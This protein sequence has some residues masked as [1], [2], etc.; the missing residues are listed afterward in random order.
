MS[1]KKPEL[2]ATVVSSLLALILAS[3]MSSLAQVPGGKAF[4]VRSWTTANG[5]PQNSI[6]AIVQTRD[7]YL[8]MGTASGLVRF[9]G[10]KFKVFD[11]SDTPELKSDRILSL[12]EDREGALW[13]GTELGGLVRYADG[14]FTGF[15]TKDG[16]PS[17]Q[18]SEILEDAEGYTVVRTFGGTVRIK[19]GKV[20]SDP[21]YERFHDQFP[22]AYAR[23][24]SV[25][26]N[27]N[28]VLGHY[29]NGDVTDYDSVKLTDNSTYRGLYAFP[30][31][32]MIYGF[33]RILVAGENTWVATREALYRISQ[34]NPQRIDKV[35]AAM[36][37]NR[38]GQP[39]F[40]TAEGLCRFE[41]N[42]L[43]CDGPPAGGKGFDGLKSLLAEND[44]S[45]ALEDREGNVWIGTSNGLF[46]FR[47][48]VITAYGAEEGLSNSNFATITQDKSGVLWMG[49]VS[50]DRSGNIPGIFRF[51]QGRFQP[52]T[53]RP[54]AAA[55]FSDAGGTWIGDG[56]LAEF[57]DE[58]AIRNYPDMK[59]VRAILRDN[60][61]TV[62]IGTSD[63]NQGL[64]KLQDGNFTHYGSADGLASNNVH[65][66]MQDRQGALW[67]G[68]EGGVSRFKDGAFTTYNTDSGLSNNFVRDIYED[69][70]GAMWIA[71]YGGGLNRLKNGRIRQITTRDGLIENT[72]SRIL[73]DGLGNFWISGNRGI[74]KISLAQLN[75][76]C[77]GRADF[78]IPVAYGVSDGMKTAECNGGGQPA[79]WKDNQG[80]L[81][82]PTAQGVVAV[83]PRKLNDLPPPV[84]IQDVLVDGIPLN[85][86]GKVEIA[87][88]QRSLVIH[89]AALSFCAP[90]KAQFK[91]KLEGYDSDW[92]AA[93][94]RREAYYDNLPP[95]RYTFR[96]RASNNDGVW[97][98]T[99]VTLPLYWRPH[100]YQTI[101][102]YGLCV[103]CLVGLG[104]GVYRWRLAY[105]IRKTERLEQTVAE[106]TTEI[107]RQKNELAEAHQ[108]LS[109][110]HEDVLSIFQQWKTAVI[111]T[112]VE[113]M[114]N[115]LNHAAERLFGR[116]LDD[117]PGLYWTDLMMMAESDADH[118]KGL[119][120]RPA[121]ERPTA[122][123]Q[124]VGPDGRRYWVEV[125]IEDDP[126]DPRRKMFFLYDVSE[127]YDL[128]SLVDDKAKFHDLIGQ[129]TAMTLV[130]QQIQDIARVDTSV[131]LEGETGT[132]K[133]L[134]A[135]A[136]H[137]AS[138]RKGKPFIAVNC[139]GL[140][141][142][143]LSSQLFGHKRGAFTGAI[144]DQKGVFEAAD[145]GTLFL[146]EI[147]D[148]PIN[149]QPSLLRALQEKEITR[150]GE[151]RPRRVNVRVIAATHRNLEREVEAGRFRNDLL[152]R[153]RVAEIHLPPLRARRE[154]IPLLVRWFL[155]QFQPESISA[156]LE[157]SR[158]AM[159]IL[160][161]Y[162]W[163]GNVRELRS[164]VEVAVIRCQGRSIQPADLPESIVGGGAR[165]IT[166]EAVSGMTGGKT[167][168][169]RSLSRR[170]EP[171]ASESRT[172]DWRRQRVLDALE[173]SGGNRA[174]A[175]RKLGISR[176]TLY[177][178]LDEL[179]LKES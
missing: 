83:D 27:H 92:V 107:V 46:Q 4:L 66:V 26:F 125:E 159:D 74:Y 171:P 104:G 177:L 77:D 152:Y 48:P 120:E 64:H 123:V 23:D 168:D 45:N 175:A 3:P 12:F 13:T 54:N 142:S 63:L 166:R 147:G 161:G 148:I 101:W 111:T 162:H 35:L 179:G 71:T 2:C 127:T 82:F 81:W 60:Q 32:Q 176:S 86:S 163:P 174:A 24:G 67:I 114:V 136:I 58:G 99:G 154:D 41:D 39:R 115:F 42:G 5:L 157:V 75:D 47:E 167:I 16:L 55:L 31:Y 59:N 98:E 36:Y 62:W 108:L 124:M 84:M 11:S 91:Y 138:S 9:D 118:V 95:G 170:S 17:N 155:G 102:F 132:G 85:R 160:M 37:T 151:T 110:A 21:I 121:G 7:G 105:L 50:A 156:K 29:Q 18:V 117:K 172:D 131:L 69:H 15:T 141:E 153:I 76:Y 119:L 52:F 128:R 33:P 10:I 28:G 79:G 139:A 53:S 150:L 44:I 43:Q 113:G 68:T 89:Y 96:V 87:A 109:R 78:V 40:V 143:L 130:Y 22:R 73:D 20:T 135:H 140:S 103:L 30:R 6:T 90:E 25:W 34:G 100:F 57:G 165:R 137:Y 56:A 126:R 38:K 93:G 133:E 178:W 106:R 88:G 146:D 70:D 19:S 134:A 164:A 14:A 51:S 80:M 144:A 94:T 1:A 129:S 8:W 158:D 169:S 116:K 145:G 97:N 61:G 72:V 49:V 112:D 173:A 122:T 149:M 65:A